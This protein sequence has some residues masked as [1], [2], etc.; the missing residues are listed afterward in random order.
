MSCKYCRG[1][2]PLY[3]EAFQ[4][5]P[6]EEWEKDSQVYIY[7][8]ILTMFP[9]DEIF[10]F[11]E[12]EDYTRRV[13]IKHCPMCGEKLGQKIIKIKY[14]DEKI[15]K[16]NINRKGNGIDLRAS[17]IIDIKE[18]GKSK[19]LEYV[20]K[21][22]ADFLK[23]GYEAKR[24]ET[25]RIGLGFAAK[26][27][28]GYFAFVLPR[29]SMFKH[30]GGIASNSLGLI[31]ESYCGD[32]NEWQLELYMQEERLKNKIKHNQR[33]CQFVLIKDERPILEEVESLGKTV[34]G[35]FGSSGKF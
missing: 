31:D 6:G 2:E 20:K 7:G 11:G 13:K 9:M 3:Q 5:S 27:P 34:R 26:L 30:T 28:E 29:S 1:E 15:N 23:N 32:E 21:A 25:I 14:I 4:R 33:L 19:G 18:N 22:N 24:G 12:E 17:R 16:I 8:D 35:S 10:K